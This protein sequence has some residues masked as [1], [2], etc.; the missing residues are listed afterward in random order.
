MLRVLADLRPQ[1]DERYKEYLASRANGTLPPRKRKGDKS[2]GTASPPGDKV[3]VPRTPTSI[4]DKSNRVS[5]NS[6]PTP[7]VTVMLTDA[8]ERGRYREAGMASR[9]PSREPSRSTREH[10]ILTPVP[11]PDRQEPPQLSQL[12]RY[13]SSRDEWNTR[14]ASTDESRHNSDFE[15]PMHRLQQSYDAD[16]KARINDPTPLS[17]TARMRQALDV[18][19]NTGVAERRWIEVKDRR[20][21][22]D[23]RMPTSQ[24]D[25]QEQAARQDQRVANVH[26]IFARRAADPQGQR[27]AEAEA[28]AK[29]ERDTRAA[30]RAR[31]EQANQEVQAKIARETSRKAF[32]DAETFERQ[33]KANEEVQAKIARETH[34]R[35]MREAASDRARREGQEPRMSRPSLDGGFRRADSFGHSPIPLQA[36]LPVTREQSVPIPSGNSPR[37]PLSPSRYPAPALYSSQTNSA[38]SS[39]S[40]DQ[41]GI[42]PMSI[43]YN[44]PDP[45]A[46][47]PLP[48]LPLESPSRTRPF[49]NGTTDDGRGSSIRDLK[50]L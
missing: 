19:E 17:E 45:V 18:V 20:L 28:R 13:A 3:Q 6:R 27:Q 32:A 29:A 11:T 1:L 33:R 35:H 24:R 49:F 38:H 37:P 50:K 48:I 42:V 21:Q 41:V 46:D 39:R 31:A 40:N 2:K 9:L 26:D 34:E 16:L 44:P 5:T 8:Q 15:A 7:G 36:S 4:E 14:S 47:M 25:L 12:H 30:D 23:D 10:N 43:P 22:E